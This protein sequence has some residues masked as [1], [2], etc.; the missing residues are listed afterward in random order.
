MEPIKIL[1]IEDDED[2][3]FLEKDILT[4]ELD[5]TINIV[6]S[7]KSLKAEDILKSDIVLLD[8]NLPDI[9]G[10]KIL[11]IIREKIK[12]RGIKFIAIADDKEIGRVFLYLMRNDLHKRPFGFIEDLHILENY[13][14]RGVGSRLIKAVIE[15][16]R[17]NNCYKIIMTSRYFND[18]AHKLYKKL[19]FQDWGKEFRML[20]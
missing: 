13:R 12:A 9:T 20:L 5:C 1:I 16:A 2:Y 3:A 19:G 4:D 6:C 10:D 17:K 8:F 18:K 15:A 14:G 7:K 11:E